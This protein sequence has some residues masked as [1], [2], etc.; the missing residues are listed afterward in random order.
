MRD[1]MRVRERY[2][3]T[4]SMMDCIRRFHAD[5]YLVGAAVVMLDHVHM[6]IQPLEREQGKWWNL[7][8]LLKGIKGVSARHINESRQSGGSIWQD[9]RYDRLI[10]SATDYTEKWN[11][12]RE[13]PLREGL[14]D[15]KTWWDGL[16]LPYG[17]GGVLRSPSVD[18][19]TS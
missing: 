7:G 8:Y 5:R 13:N 3:S 15:A 10:R 1:R 6:L 17:P 4:F 18:Q 12:I 19:P 14:V 2:A 9:E 16:W 11:Y